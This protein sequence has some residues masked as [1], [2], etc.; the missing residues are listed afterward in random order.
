MTNPKVTPFDADSELFTNTV[1]QLRRDQNKA[2]VK[3]GAFV[4][5]VFFGFGMVIAFAVSASGTAP[6]IAKVFG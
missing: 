5:L 1:V 4:G 2:W 6:T 3:F